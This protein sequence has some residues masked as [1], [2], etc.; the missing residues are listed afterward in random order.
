MAEPWGAVQWHIRRRGRLYHPE[1]QQSRAVESCAERF[2]Q[3]KHRDQG[4]RAVRS[5][6]GF[7]LRAAGRV[8][9]LFPAIIQWTALGGSERWR[10]AHHADQAARDIGKA[11][12]ELTTSAPLNRPTQ[13]S[14][15][16]VLCRNRWKHQR[17]C[18]ASRCL[19]KYY[20]SSTWTKKAEMTS[21][22][23][24]FQCIAAKS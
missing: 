17:N 18:T 2:V 7:Y 16:C 3:F 20:L 8:R 14:N 11:V 12:F 15:P 9:S 4:E 19:E 21:R 1:V 13:G 24:H 10:A 23:E 22:Y 6:M 5:R